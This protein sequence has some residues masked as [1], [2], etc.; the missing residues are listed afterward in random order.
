MTAKNPAPLTLEQ[1]N[2]LLRSRVSELE[3]RIAS[4]RSMGVAVAGERTTV[5]ELWDSYESLGRDQ[6]IDFE[7]VVRELEGMS[8]GAPQS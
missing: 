8:H 3:K 1:E 6:L 5:G 4:I 7:D 2:S